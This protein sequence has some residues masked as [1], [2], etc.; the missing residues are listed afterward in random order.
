MNKK[1]GILSVMGG[2]VLIVVVLWLIGIINIDIGEFG[3]RDRF[4][5]DKMSHI[6]SPYEATYKYNTNLKEE[7]RDLK[8]GYIECEKGNVSKLFEYNKS[9]LVDVNGCC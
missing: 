2:L 6:E 4:C 1:G 3:D 9:G 5:K 8:D 7:N